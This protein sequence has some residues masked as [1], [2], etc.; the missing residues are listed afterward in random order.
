MDPLAPRQGHW[1]GLVVGGP[2][3]LLSGE[4]LLRAEAAHLAHPAQDWPQ[5]LAYHGHG[6]TL[7]PHSSTNS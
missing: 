4:H 2:E 1:Q 7:S 3:P 6:S 5:Q